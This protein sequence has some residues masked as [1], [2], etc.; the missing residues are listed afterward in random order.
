MYAD[1]RLGQQKNVVGCDILF[2]KP[3]SDFVIDN[4]GSLDQL[5]C[6]SDH[7]VSHIKGLALNY[8]YVET[9]FQK[10]W[11]ICTLLLTA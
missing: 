2:Q 5:L 7:I 8:E 1:F 3:K 9:V 4:T 10:K 11:Y 6:H